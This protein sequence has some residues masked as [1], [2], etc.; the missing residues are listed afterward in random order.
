VVNVVTGGPAVGGALAEHADVNLLAFT[1][2]TAVGRDILRASAG[3]M[4]RTL[5]E[6]GGK[7][8]NIVFA[9]ADLR[10]AIPGAARAIFGNSGQ[11]CTAGSRIY[12]ARAITEKLSEGVS[13]FAEKLRIGPGIDPATQLGPVVSERQRQRILGHVQ[14]AK[15]EGAALITGGG[16]V[17]RPELSGGYFVEPTVFG[18]VTQSMSIVREEIFGPVVT[19]TPFDDLDEVIAAANDSIYGL[20]AGVWTKDIDTANAMIDALETGTVWINCYQALD[21]SVPFGG[22]GASGLGRE[23]GYEAVA[24][25]T[26]IKSVVQSTKN[27]D[28]ERSS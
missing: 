15:N 9:D 22:I 14:G 27:L 17:D 6:L 10:R 2:S 18:D 28:W 5:L 25:Y 12:A 21:A 8:P 3:N 4:K 26:E 11:V 7:S 16:A 20:A 19:I 24:E 23:Y 1:G 13:A